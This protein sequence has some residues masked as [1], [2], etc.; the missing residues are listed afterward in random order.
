M[1]L[2]VQGL[3]RGNSNKHSNKALG[4]TAAANLGQ[5]DH[6]HAALT[7]VKSASSSGQGCSSRLLP[8]PVSCRNQPLKGHKQSDSSSGHST[9]A[10]V[11]HTVSVSST[12][13]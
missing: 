8:G 10:P 11:R 12:E 6:P 13:Q 5:Y 9:Y 7:G 4:E 1:G 2:T 3:L